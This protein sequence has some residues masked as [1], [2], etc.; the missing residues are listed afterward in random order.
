[1]LKWAGDVKSGDPDNLEARAAAYYWKNL[2]P[3]FLDFRREREGIPPNNLLGMHTLYFEPLLPEP[4]W[5]RLICQHWEFITGINTIITALLMISWNHTGRLP[6]H[7]FWDRTE[8]RWPYWTKLICP[9]GNCLALQQLTCFSM[10]SAALDECR[11]AHHTLWRNALR[12]CQKDFYPKLLW[13]M[14][15]NEYRIMWGHG[16]FWSSGRN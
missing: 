7:W 1:M 9:K 15:L 2:F 6:M 8:W 16:S 14:R 10:T 4:G 12:K 5:F 3:R 13:V 11:A